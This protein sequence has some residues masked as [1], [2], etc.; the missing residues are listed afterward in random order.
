MFFQDGM[1][2]HSKS[3]H[4]STTIERCD[5]H[6]SI[7][8]KKWNE[9]VTVINTY[10]LV[11][12]YL[13]NKKN[14]TISISKIATNWTQLEQRTADVSD[15]ICYQPQG[16]PKTAPQCPK[17]WAPKNR[18]D[19]LDEFS[20][21]SHFGDIIKYMHIYIYSHES[22]RVIYKYT[23]KIFFKYHK[24]AG[25]QCHFIHHKSSKL[26]TVIYIVSLRNKNMGKGANIGSKTTLRFSG[27][28]FS[29][30]PALHPPAP[31]FD[32]PPKR[33]GIRKLWKTP[34]Q[35]QR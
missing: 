25:W 8:S 12:W 10:N 33:K 20:A 29:T 17:V 26:D 32:T 11:S 7:L 1:I 16:S 31:R 35:D 23:Y 13:A 5:S 2:V 15:R 4:E 24:S 22:Y 14:K 21:A 19:K 28:R 6:I 9:P 34:L 3:S 30:S 18:S 27:W